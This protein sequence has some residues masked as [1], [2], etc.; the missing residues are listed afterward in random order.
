M[1]IPESSNQRLTM[2]FNSLYGN[3]NSGGEACVETEPVISSEKSLGSN[4]EVVKHEDLERYFAKPG[5]AE[6]GC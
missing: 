1:S 4:R 5:Q 3:S 2:F 6:W